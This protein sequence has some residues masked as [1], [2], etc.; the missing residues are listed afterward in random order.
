MPYDPGPRRR[1]KALAML[2]ALDQAR[3]DREAQG[4]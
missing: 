4:A 2:S 1:E 3:H